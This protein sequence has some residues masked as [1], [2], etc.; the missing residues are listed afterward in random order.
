ME[1]LLIY[2]NLHPWKFIFAFIM[3]MIGIRE[4]IT[5]IIGTSKINSV[6]NKLDEIIKILKKGK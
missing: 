5:W 3:I 6:N 1:E 2:M 4:I